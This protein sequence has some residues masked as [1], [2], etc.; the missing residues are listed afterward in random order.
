MWTVCLFWFAL[1]GRPEVGGVW[2]GD[3]PDAVRARLGEPEHKQLSLG[4]EF[5]DYD[6]QGLSLIWDRDRPALRVI[7]VKAQQAGVVQGVR[8]GDSASV[9]R[10]QWGEPARE[11]QNGQFVD[12]PRVEWVQTA[13]LKRGRVVEITLTAR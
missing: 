12:F 7:I 1:Q 4:L 13:E 8:V 5:W 10:A 11:R 6:R 2:F 9:V 3:R